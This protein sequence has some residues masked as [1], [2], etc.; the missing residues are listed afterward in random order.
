MLRPLDPRCRV[1]QFSSRLSDG[2]FQ[3]LAKFLE[4]YPDVPLRAFGS[5]DGS[6]RDLDFLQF[7]PQLRAFQADAMYQ[8]LQDIQGLNHLP[9]DATFIGLGRTKQRLS[10][11]PLGR[12]S[13][14]RRLYLEGQT[15]DIEVVSELRSLHSVTLRSI[16]LPDLS[17]LVP[18]TDLRALDLKLGG[19]RDLGLLPAFEQLLYL[20]V[21]M[22]RGF[23]D[24]SPVADV[25]SLEELFVQALKNVTQL[26]DLSKLRSLR[27]VHLE[28][29]KGLQDLRPL[30]TAPALEEVRIIDMGHLQP[31]DVAVLAGKATLRRATVGL[32]S[33]TKNDAVSRLLPLPAAEFGRHPALSD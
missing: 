25:P 2:E 15:K 23:S 9:S 18:L 7:F 24:L 33:R 14:L 11:S 32:G 5:Y 17:L 27:R 6:I 26:P 16:T 10:L 19:T 21:W 13:R 8:S 12:F 28:T 22:V 1:V 31:S 20:E 3:R 29:M 30:L 4:D